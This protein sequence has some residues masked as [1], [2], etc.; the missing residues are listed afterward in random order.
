MCALMR[1]IGHENPYPLPSPILPRYPRAGLYLFP[2]PMHGEC[3]W[4]LSQS[5]RPGSRHGPLCQFYR[6]RLPE[7][8]GR[9]P[10]IMRLQRR[11]APNAF[12][13]VFANRKTSCRNIQDPALFSPL[14]NLFGMIK[15]RIII[16]GIFGNGSTR[17]NIRGLCTIL[18]LTGLPPVF[19]AQHYPRQ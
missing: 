2:E 15:G 19:S 3:G 10:W 12:Y 18:D 5:E 1:R 9:R 11:P 16:G 8:H 17:P 13:S 14:V 4:S 6:H 7:S